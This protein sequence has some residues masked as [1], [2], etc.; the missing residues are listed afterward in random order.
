MDLVSAAQRCNDVEVF[1][2]RIREKGLLTSIAL[3]CSRS[4]D[5]IPSN[6]GDDRQVLLGPFME[7]TPRFSTRGVPYLIVSAILYLRHLLSALQ[8]V[9]YLMQGHDV[10]ETL[11]PTQTIG[12]A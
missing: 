1:L 3:A 11:Q 12:Q 5:R 10:S 2:V 7:P 8:Q 4:A 9:K 6:A